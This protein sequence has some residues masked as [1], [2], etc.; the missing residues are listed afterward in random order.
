MIYVPP[1]LVAH[2]ALRKHSLYDR[3]F[4]FWIAIFRL[5]NDINLMNSWAASNGV[6]IWRTFNG[7]SEETNSQMRL[8]FFCSA[9]HIG[10]EIGF[11]QCCVFDETAVIY[12]HC[13]DDYATLPELHLLYIASLQYIAS[14]WWPHCQLMMRHLSI[15]TF[16]VSKTFLILR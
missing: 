9:T 11:W 15:I 2:C 13:A 5:A 12:A 1:C 14:A 8:L 7:N 4:F 3:K 6:H 10:I 16:F